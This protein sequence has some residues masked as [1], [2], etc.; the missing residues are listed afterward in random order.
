MFVH[1]LDLKTEWRHR[2]KAGAVSEEL[3][4]VKKNLILAG[5]NAGTMGNWMIEQA[6]G[7]EPAFG[8]PGTPRFNPPD[9]DMQ[10]F[11][12]SPAGDVNRMNGYSACHFDSRPLIAHA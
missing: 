12:R 5:L 8:D 3:C 11:G 6:I 7:P 10:T 9:L 2:E 1:L 4:K